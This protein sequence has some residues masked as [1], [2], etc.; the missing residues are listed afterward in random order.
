MGIWRIRMRTLAEVDYKS[1]LVVGL[2]PA[3]WKSQRFEGKPLVDIS[4]IPMI[5][6]VYARASMA[7]HL[8]R[9]VVLTDDE[10]INDYCE[11]NQMTCIVIKEDCRTGTDRCAHALKLLD[12]SLFVN[13]Q[14]DEPLINPS[15]IDNL[16]ENFDNNIGVANAYTK[17]D[18]DYKLADNNVVKVVFDKVKNA[19]Y[20][21]RLPISDYQQLGLYA[22]NRGMLDAFP[23][24]T[25]GELEIG[26]SVEM[27]RYLENGFNVKM[28][29]VEDEGLSVDTPNDLKL[30]ELKIKGYH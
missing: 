11:K 27:L 2:I 30:V 20:Y 26:E 21:S 7:N 16:I 14:G 17:I 5:R 10:R 25:L 19:L 18:Q 3:R 15:A 23:K 22:F 6:R 12:G 4:G 28:V 8:D 1:D 9:V 29:E 13:I 24:F